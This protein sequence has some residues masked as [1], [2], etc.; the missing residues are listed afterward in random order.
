MSNCN[1]VNQCI[2]SD[3]EFFNLGHKFRNLLERAFT[4]VVVER[5]AG[6]DHRPPLRQKGVI[7]GPVEA[8]SAAQADDTQHAALRAAAA[9]SCAGCGRMRFTTA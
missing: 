6:M 9:R 4:D 7:D 3:V 1:H 2:A 8:A 5:R